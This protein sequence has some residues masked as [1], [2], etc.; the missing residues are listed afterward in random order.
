MGFS[1]CRI[2][3]CTRRPAGAGNAQLAL[4]PAK[5]SGGSSSCVRLRQGFGQING[6]PHRPLFR[7]GLTS[8]NQCVGCKFRSPRLN[9]GQPRAPGK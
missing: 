9:L 8:P 2:A 5:A 3:C 6:A 1:T 7:T 4:A